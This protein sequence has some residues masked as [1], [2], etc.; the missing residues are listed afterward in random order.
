MKRFGLCPPRVVKRG[1]REGASVRPPRRVDLFTVSLPSRS[2]AVL[3]ARR[4]LRE[5]LIVHLLGAAVVTLALTGGADASTPSLGEGSPDFSVSAQPLRYDQPYRASD[6]IDILVSMSVMPYEKK[7]RAKTRVRLGPDLAW[8]AGDSVR[9]A[10]LSGREAVERWTVTIRSL[11]DGNTELRAAMSVGGPE[12]LKEM[13][14]ALPILVDKG[15]VT[16]GTVRV[17]RT[18]A[19][20]GKQRYR[21]GGR[22]LVPIDGPEEVTTAEITRGPVVLKSVTAE[23][24]ECP[25][26]L[27]RTLPFVVFVK[28]NG[29]IHSKRFLGDEGGAGG[30][31]PAMIQS[32]ET[33]LEHWKFAPARTPTRSIAHWMFVRVPVQGTAP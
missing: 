11:K 29:M 4:T 23:C 25:D 18:E 12:N 20:R 26:T 15:I 33:A 6:P 10:D 31:I 27:S 8:L 3:V 24:G 7:R 21:Y 28:S 17:L 5:K 22:Y 1:D 9:I 14:I 16:F 19:V 13:D 2:M 32:A 30:T